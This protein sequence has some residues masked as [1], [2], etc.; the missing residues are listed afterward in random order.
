MLPVRVDDTNLA[1]TWVFLSRRQ[2]HIL[3]SAYCQRLCM[4]CKTQQWLD[5][6]VTLSKLSGLPQLIHSSVLGIIKTRLLY[7]SLVQWRHNV[8]S[9]TRGLLLS[10]SYTNGPSILPINN[11]IGGG[12]VWMEW[13][14]IRKWPS[15]PN[16]LQLQIKAPW[17]AC[18]TG[19]CPSY[20]P[21]ILH[22]YL[23]Y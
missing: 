10:C 11:Q 21:Y 5:Q 9:T 6:D 15:V 4:H 1:T 19:W 12:Y 3:H 8:M 14:A 7:L 2:L 13:D 18:L 17:R 22:L 23:I 20:P 16:F